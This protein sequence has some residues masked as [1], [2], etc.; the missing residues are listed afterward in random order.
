M[1][2]TTNYLQEIKERINSISALQGEFIVNKEHQIGKQ[3]DRID[4]AFR[5]DKSFIV[6][7]SI[8]FAD[9]GAFSS[10]KCKSTDGEVDSCMKAEVNAKPM[11]GEKGPLRF[12]KE[13]NDVIQAVKHSAVVSD[14]REL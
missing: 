13:P 2:A 11:M 14:V 3:E 8:I 12:V 7:C 5:K 4:V 9:P 10:S 6:A 1:L